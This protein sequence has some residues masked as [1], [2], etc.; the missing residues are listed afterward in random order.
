KMGGFLNRKSDGNPGWQ[1]L[2][3]GQLQLFWMVE[4]AKALLG[5]EIYG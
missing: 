4:G 2:W 5:D 3:K 1:T